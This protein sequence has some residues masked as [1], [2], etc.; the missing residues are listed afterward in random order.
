[1]DNSTYKIKYESKGTYNTVFMYVHSEC[2]CVCSC[3]HVCVYV[4]MW[5]VDCNMDYSPPP[6]H[7][8]PVPYTLCLTSCAL[9]LVP[10]A[11]FLTP[12]ALHPVPYTLCLTPCSLHLVPYTLCLTPCALHPVPYTL[13]PLLHVVS[14]TDMF[15]LTYVT[16]KR[17]T[18]CVL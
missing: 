15:L 5:Q 6:H 13:F 12:C 16:G 11:L 4:C 17:A 3:Q 1:M 7:L 18:S 9:Y 14:I 8:H 2:L 10:Y